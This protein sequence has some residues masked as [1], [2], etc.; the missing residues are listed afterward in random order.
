LPPEIEDGRLEMGGADISTGLQDGQDLQEGGLGRV[1]W[2][3]GD[4]GEGGALMIG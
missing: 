2:W 4:G 3:G 1:V